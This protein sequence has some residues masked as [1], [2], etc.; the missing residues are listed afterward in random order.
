[1][2]SPGSLTPPPP[3]YFSH[4]LPLSEA[5]TFFYSFKCNII[6]SLV[7]LLFSISWPCVLSLWYEFLSRASPCY[8]VLCFRPPPLS[9]VF[10]PIQVFLRNTQ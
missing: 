7:I 8:F 1:M 5:P 10:G 6:L 2:L 4:S 9:L 3:F